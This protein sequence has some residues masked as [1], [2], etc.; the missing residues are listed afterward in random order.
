M[1]A[2]MSLNFLTKLFGASAKHGNAAEKEVSAEPPEVPLRR[3]ST[4]KSG[5]LKVRKSKSSQNIKD[6]VFGAKQEDDDVEVSV[7]DVIKEIYEVVQS[8]DTSAKNTACEQSKR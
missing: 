4:S 2:K 3:V 1:T 7:E 8:D 5:K 6:V